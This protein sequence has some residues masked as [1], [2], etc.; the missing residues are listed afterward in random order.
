MRSEYGDIPFDPLCRRIFEDIGDGCTDEKMDRF[1]SYLENLTKSE[2]LPVTS[3]RTWIAI[4]VAV[5]IAVLSILYLTTRFSGDGYR[6]RIGNEIAAGKVGKTIASGKGD[7]L[8]IRFDNGST[9]TLETD[10]AAVVT[11]TSSESVRI[12][13]LHGRVSAQVNGNGRTKWLVDGG[14]YSVVVVGTKFDVSWNTDTEVFDLS[15]TEGEVLVEGTPASKN[16]LAVSSGYCLRINKKTRVSAISPITN[17]Q[18][19][20]AVIAEHA[21]GDTV[22][23]HNDDVATTV[24][25][26]TVSSVLVDS[27]ETTGIIRDP[28]KARTAQNRRCRNHRKAKGAMDAKN[29]RL[30]IQATDNEKAQKNQQWLAFYEKKDFAQA[31]TSAEAVGIGYLLDTVDV[32]RLWKLVQTARNVGNFRVA[33]A[34]LLKYRERFYATQRA[35]LSAFFLG[36]LY[37]ENR[38]NWQMAIRWFSTYIDESPLGDMAE[39]AMGRLIVAHVNLKR[40][41]DAKKLSRRYLANYPNGLHAVTART[42]L[43][44]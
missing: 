35:R 14:P 22:S 34:A 15:V 17:P 29:T 44:Q 16:G 39:D 32:D 11:E 38:S 7:T 36:K 26:D 5:S 41:T 1:C 33:E 2:N 43:G 37:A 12:K 13:L 40:T 20:D 24:P 25:G 9:F 8:P 10:T 31:M 18:S 28:P 6:F 42:V 27:G 19:E 3:L 30:A 21:P 23:P 4:S